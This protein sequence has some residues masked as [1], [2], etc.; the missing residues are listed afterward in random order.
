LL[1][2]NWTLEHKVALLLKLT[3]YFREKVKETCWFIS[4]LTPGLSS[5]L[6]FFDEEA[7]LAFLLG[8]E[9]PLA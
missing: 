9:A 8:L 5:C 6:L 3:K 4:M 7:V 2:I 1:I